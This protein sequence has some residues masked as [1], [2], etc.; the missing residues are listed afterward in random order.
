VRVI[1]KRTIR[2]FWATHADAEGPLSE[3]HRL[4]RRADWAGPADVKATLRHASIVS[5]D[6]IV[7]NIGGNK[8]RL[9]VRVDYRFRVLYIRFV[10]THADY[11]RID[12]TRV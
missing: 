11:D 2:E 9:V 8:Y 3:W 7:F 10:G 1:S 12:V 4:A 6:R 5:R